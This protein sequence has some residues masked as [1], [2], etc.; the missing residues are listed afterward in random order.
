[1]KVLETIIELLRGQWREELDIDISS[2]DSIVR[3]ILCVCIQLVNNFYITI[4]VLAIEP[5][6]LRQT[7]TEH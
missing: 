7:V 5:A 1:M 6:I 4:F 3:F 2:S